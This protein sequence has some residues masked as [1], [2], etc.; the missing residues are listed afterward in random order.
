MGETHSCHDQLQAMA[1]G[2]LEMPML[3]RNSTRRW[4]MKEQNIFTMRS[5]RLPK[6]KTEML[7]SICWCQ[8]SGRV[9]NTN[10]ELEQRNSRRCYIWKDVM[11]GNLHC[12]V[13]KARECLNSLFLQKD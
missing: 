12:L 11:Y 5:G 9:E 13:E 6:L 7:K 8:N 4:K 2:I 1:D 3:V 10:E